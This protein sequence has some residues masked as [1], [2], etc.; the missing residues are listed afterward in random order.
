MDAKTEGTDTEGCCA[1][2]HTTETKQETSLA[3]LLLNLPFSSLCYQSCSTMLDL[4]ATIV[5]L[6]HEVQVCGGENI[7]VPQKNHRMVVVE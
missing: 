3:L 5:S 6:E 2:F 1:N 7:A 4:T